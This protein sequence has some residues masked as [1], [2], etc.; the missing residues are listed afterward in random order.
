MIEPKQ[1]RSWMC[2][3]DIELSQN[4]SVHNFSQQISPFKGEMR[5]SFSLKQP[6]HDEAMK[7][8]PLFLIYSTLKRRWNAENFHS[9]NFSAVVSPQFLQRKFSTRF[10]VSISLYVRKIVTS[11]VHPSSE[12]SSKKTLL[13]EVEELKLEWEK[14]EMPKEYRSA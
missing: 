9:G 4:F 6:L 11:F 1:M 13:Q 14:R 10:I 5:K 7:T 3:A 2:S 8:S 12:K